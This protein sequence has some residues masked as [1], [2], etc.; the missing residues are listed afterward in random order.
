MK[1]IYNSKH[2]VINY[3]WDH[4]NLHCLLDNFR[5]ETVTFHSSFWHYF[6]NPGTKICC[7]KPSLKLVCGKITLDICFE[8]LFFLNCKVGIFSR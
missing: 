3:M 2:Y 1:K 4:S 5:F 6:V 7:H 8:D